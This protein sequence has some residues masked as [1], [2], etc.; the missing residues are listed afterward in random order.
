MHQI[1]SNLDVPKSVLSVRGV[2]HAYATG[3][4]IA[5]PD[6]I[7][8]NTEV[9]IV[10]GA[11]GAGKST[12]IHLVVGALRIQSEASQIVVDDQSLYGKSAIELDALRPH[13]I[14][15]MPQRVHLLTSLSVWDNVTLPLAMTRALTGPERERA[16]V[17]MQD[18]GISALGNK[19]AA[20][21]SVG[22]AA[23]ACLVRALLAKP[24]LLVADEPTAALDSH[25]AENICRM[26]AMYAAQGGAVLL[27]SHDKSVDAHLRRH[28]AARTTHIELAA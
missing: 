5:F 2:V 15:W 3:A 11:S 7:I 23:R 9:T 12:L 22:Q 1:A 27:A 24:K 26:I 10:R 13:I 16:H 21:V 8:T 19:F 28:G 4:P 18:A 25:S 14:G 20:D 17:L 6:L